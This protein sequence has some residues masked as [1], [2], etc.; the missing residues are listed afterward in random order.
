MRGTWRRRLLVAVGLGVLFCSGVVV[1]LAAST[2]PTLSGETLNGS[3]SGS[4]ACNTPTFSVTGT[5]PTGNPYPGTFSE[6]GSW[7]G[8]VANSFSSTFTIADGTTTI[9]GSKSGGS[10]G[11]CAVI[12]VN[13][14]TVLLSTTPYT[15]TI[16]TPSGTFLDQGTSSGVVFIDFRGN[17][18]QDETF[19]STLAQPVPLAPTSVAQ[20]MNGGW[21]NFPQF[22]NQGACVSF[23]TKGGG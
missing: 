12:T 9:T 1:A 17:V 19:T 4:P 6:T 3:G 15:A 21:Q 22:K 7:T 5:I 20:C 10:E 8:S 23:V 13:S 16:H 11:D 18:T 2:P 14:A